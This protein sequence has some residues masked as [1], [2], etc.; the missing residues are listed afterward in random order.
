[1]NTIANLKQQEFL[2]AIEILRY[3]IMS[4]KYNIAIH[5]AQNAS[6]K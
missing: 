6:I 2:Q 4:I 1:M 3:L 5:E